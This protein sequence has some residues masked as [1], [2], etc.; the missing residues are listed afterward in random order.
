MED[1]TSLD[2][3]I[4]QL[5]RCLDTEQQYLLEQSTEKLAQ[6][7][8]KKQ[9]ILRSVADFENHL[10][11]QQQ[12]IS[13]QLRKRLDECRTKNRENGSLAAFHLKVT[14]GAISHLR[15]LM[16]LPEVELYGADGT[17]NHTL[18]NREIGVA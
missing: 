4:D 5:L 11:G 6:I 14:R 8:D 9:Q 15:S 2:A 12:P 13:D 3:L 1:Q 7:S 10:T 17:T 16:P 18:I